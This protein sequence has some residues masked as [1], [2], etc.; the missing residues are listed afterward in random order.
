MR[1]VVI[2]GVVLLSLTVLIAGSGA[3]AQRAR[4]IEAAA[5]S[6]PTQVEVTNFPAVQ[7]VSGTV[8]VGNIPAVQSVA[9]SVQVSNLPLD[10]EGNMRAAVVTTGATY[11]F[12]KIAD[13]INLS[14]GQT[15]HLDP[16]PVA[17][18]R[19][20]QVTVHLRPNGAGGPFNGC[21]FFG[22]DGVFAPAVC[23]QLSSDLVTSMFGAEVVGPEAQV[24]V[25][26]E[27]DSETLV[28]VWMYLSN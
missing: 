3:T 6:R 22:G 21:L 19:H 10:A 14:A 11:R 27:Y 16:I 13:G 12:I 24:S 25:R 5:A 4:V 28:D 23:G 7:T 17:G 8:N 26:A 18:W 20:V 9:G 2:W 1:K 15:V